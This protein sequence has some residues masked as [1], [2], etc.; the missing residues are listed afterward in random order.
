[1]NSPQF[2]VRKFIPRTIKKRIRSICEKVLYPQDTSIVIKNFF[3]TNFKKKVL[4]SYIVE[5]FCGIPDNWLHTN[6]QEAIA[7]AQAFHSLAYQVDVIS[8]L[9]KQQ[10]NFSQY[11]CIFGFGDPLCQSYKLGNNS[12]TIIHYATGMHVT[13]QNQATLERA[14]A[15]F[16]QKN[17]W[18]IESCRVVDSY[19]AEQAILSDAIIVL[20]NNMVSETYMR[21]NNCPIYNV[22][23]TFNISLPDTTLDSKNFSI[24][25][26]NFLWFSSGGLIH[27][28]L[29]LL[30]NAFSMR[31]DINLHIAGPVYSEPRFIKA[32]S[33]E[34]DR[35]NVF[36]YGVIDVR[37]EKFKT[38]IRSCAFGILPSCSEGQAS[39]IKNL[40]SNGVLPVVT[41]ECGYDFN[42]Y[43]FIIEH[44]D[45]DSVIQAIDRCQSID[46]VELKKLSEMCRTETREHSSIVNFSKKITE[47]L[48]HII[49][50]T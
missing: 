22:N 20:G 44:T 5:P 36:T 19:W 48:N 40:M 35:P 26:K 10:I 21:H 37:S 6:R 9:S 33:A 3:Q 8:Y 32:F 45:M 7:I 11:D 46:E 15:V 24:A 4:I 29:D 1:M 18:L 28:G 41:P 42:K 14:K 49:N 43:S 17:V 30:L 47:A 16:K 12:S 27:K 34:L 13:H 25:K 2:S 39:S 38:L 23:T 31:E 50:M